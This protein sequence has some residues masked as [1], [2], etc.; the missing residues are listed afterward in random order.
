MMTEDNCAMYDGEVYKKVADA[1]FTYMAH[2]SLKSYVNGLLADIDVADVL[3]PYI[4]QILNLLSE[5]SCGMV[6]QLTI[7]YDYIECQPYAFCFHISKKCF[8][9]DPKDLRGSP[10]AFVYYKF[11]EKVPKPKYFMEGNYSR[12]ENS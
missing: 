6:K 9:K 4:G 7:D 11:N 1:K 3:V 5:P 2:K 12:F 8:E 10:R